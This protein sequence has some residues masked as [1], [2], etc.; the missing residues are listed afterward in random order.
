VSSQDLAPFPPRRCDRR[1]P[2]RAR[3][4]HTRARQVEGAF[5]QGVG[6][7]TSEEMIWGDGAHP[8]RG[9]G[10][11]GGGGSVPRGARLGSDR[12]ACDGYTTKT[13]Q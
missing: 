3:D 1:S 7:W 6:R 9:G 10:G 5:V 2:D 8:A 11:G 12:A 13:N 4:A